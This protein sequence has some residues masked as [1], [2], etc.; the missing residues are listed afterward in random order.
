VPF[1]WVCRICEEHADR[2]YASRDLAEADARLH[3]SAR[4]PD[5]TA[6]YRIIHGFARCQWRPRRVFSRIC[7]KPAT[8]AHPPGVRIHLC[9]QHRAE[10]A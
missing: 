1:A 5:R 9:E 7:G 4:H 2:E 6:K 10:G 8:W 3:A